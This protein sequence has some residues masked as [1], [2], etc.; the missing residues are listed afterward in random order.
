M[1]RSHLRLPQNQWG[2]SIAGIRMQQQ[3]LLGPVGTSPFSLVALSLPQLPLTTSQL[4]RSSFTCSLPQ[5]SLVAIRAHLLPSSHPLSLFILQLP[6][7]VPSSYSLH[8]FPSPQYAVAVVLVLN[9][10]WLLS[11]LIPEFLYFAM[12]AQFD[13]MPVGPVILNALLVTA[14]VTVAQR[15]DS[16][17]ERLNGPLWLSGSAA[18]GLA[19]GVVPP[20]VFLLILTILTGFSAARAVLSSLAATA[21]ASASSST[22]ASSIS[23]SSSTLPSA[24]TKPQALAGPNW[25]SV[26][27]P[28]VAAIAGA[29][30]SLGVRLLAVGV[31]AMLAV[32]LHHSGKITFQG[33]SSTATTAAQGKHVKAWKFQPMSMIQGL[34]AFA[35]LVAVMRWGNSAFLAWMVL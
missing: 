15:F 33:E 19:T 25:L 30:E 21:T 24:T 3:R 29:A 35:G 32:W 9:R 8:F 1:D 6:L 5:P 4:T 26:V 12:L 28:A 34:V 31:Y 2:Q 20:L 23:S 17:P 10:R 13:V 11:E 22:L 14:V 27:A 18:V 16:D 7:A